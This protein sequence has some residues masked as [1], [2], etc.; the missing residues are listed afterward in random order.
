M[1]FSISLETVVP[2]ELYLVIYHPG[3]PFI[4]TL[5]GSNFRAFGTT[6]T[7]LLARKYALKKA[8]RLI[9]VLVV[10]TANRSKRVIRA[11]FTVMT[12]INTSKVSSAIF[13]L[14]P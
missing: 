3:K 13:W 4:A 1:L 11:V 6:S 5:T 7:L 10:S 9:R 14:T 12:L 2:G 8:V